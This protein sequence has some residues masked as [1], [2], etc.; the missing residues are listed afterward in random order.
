[1]AT[2][3]KQT[4]FMR[5][6][7]VNSIIQADL[8]L[9]RRLSKA[10]IWVGKPNQEGEYFAPEVVGITE[11][12][13]NQGKDVNSVSRNEVINFASDVLVLK[14]A[15]IDLPKSNG[16]IEHIE[17]PAA[18]TPAKKK[19]VRAKSETRRK[20]VRK[21]QPE[22]ED[23]GKKKGRFPKTDATVSSGPATVAEEEEKGSASV[24]KEIEQPEPADCAPEPEPEPKTAEPKTATGKAVTSKQAPK[25]DEET[26]DLEDEPR[27]RNGKHTESR[28][29]SVTLKNPGVKIGSCCIPYVPAL[30]ICSQMYA[31]NCLLQPYTDPVAREI[32]DRINA[33]IEDVQKISI[34]P[35]DKK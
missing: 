31:A 33:F 23:E 26:D 29:S 9:S 17:D 10:T 30:A 12:I 28:P 5:Y 24:E 21:P 6:A 4:T 18:E 25:S 13:H 34:I 11:A 8:A 35:S 15:Q 7:R 1:M 16:R 32:S 2:T 14:T 19:R 20:R 27:G 3:K 22:S